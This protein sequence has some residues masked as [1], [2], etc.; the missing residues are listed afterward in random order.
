MDKHIKSF[1][2]FLEARKF[3]DRQYIVNYRNTACIYYTNKGIVMRYP[4]GIAWEE[5]EEPENKEKLD[6]FVAQL[7]AY[8]DS[9]KKLP[10]NKQGSN[11]PVEDV[12]E[13]MKNE[14]VQLTTKEILNNE[15][16]KVKDVVFHDKMTKV[17]FTVEPEDF[18]YVDK[19]YEF[20]L[21]L[22]AG[23]MK[24][25]EVNVFLKYLTGTPPDKLTYSVRWDKINPADYVKVKSAEDEE[26]VDEYEEEEKLRRKE[27]IDLDP[28]KPAK[29]LKDLDTFFTGSP[30]Q[31]EE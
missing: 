18:K 30:I 3:D 10:S 8:V 5:R 12:R 1:Q 20:K 11:P 4:T 2:L 27:D 31:E 16:D 26:F 7:T 9:Y 6:D 15:F 17:T 22:G 25:R 14:D 21:E 29:H 13:I 19:D 24:K 23:S 28:T